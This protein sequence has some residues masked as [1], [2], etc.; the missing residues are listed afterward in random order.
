[1]VTPR[2]SLSQQQMSISVE[3][4]RD[5]IDTVA[6][7]LVE[8]QETIKRLGETLDVKVDQISQLEQALIEAHDVIERLQTERGA[9]IAGTSVATKGKE[10]GAP[11]EPSK[12][13]AAVVA[14]A[15]TAAT[16]VQV[17]S[18]SALRDAIRALEEK[19]QAQAALL[20]KLAAEIEAEQR[21]LGITK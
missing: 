15:E 3:Q 8:S 10:D 20:A 4:I 18:V 6:P 17:S 21:V 12:A 2:P 9:D 16:P 7:V 14:T 13:T 11:Q 5:E 19:E 1:M